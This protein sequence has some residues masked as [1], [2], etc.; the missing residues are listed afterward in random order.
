MNDGNKDRR[1]I[2]TLRK[3]ERVRFTS[4]NKD[5]NVW[6]NDGNKDRREI[7]TLRKA[8]RVRFTSK[9]RDENV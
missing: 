6:M 7:S 4:K 9:N 3:V 5:E 1:E 2:S 8:E